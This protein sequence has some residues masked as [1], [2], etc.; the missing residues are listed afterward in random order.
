[1][2]DDYVLLEGPVQAWGENFL[3]QIPLVVGGDKLAPYAKGIGEVRDGYLVIT[4]LPWLA[5]KLNIGDGNLVVVDNADGKL[6]ITRSAAN[7]TP[8][9]ET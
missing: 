3:L 6:N 5:E 8:L 2:S 4:I 9:E 7:D 1:M